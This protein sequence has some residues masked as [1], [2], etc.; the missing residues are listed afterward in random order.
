[1]KVESETA[2][3]RRVASVIAL[4]ALLVVP[5]VATEFHLFQATLVITSAIALLGLNLLTGYGGQISLGHGALYG[6]GAYSA[7]I[8]VEKWGLPYGLGIVGAALICFVVGFLLGL[9]ALRLEGLYLALAT[10]AFA[11]ALPQVLKYKA[12][13]AVT[14]GVQG[15]TLKKPEAPF[16]LVESPDRFMYFLYLGVAVVLFACVRN[17]IQ[18]QTG[19]AIIAIRDS[20]IAASSLGIDIAMYKTTTFAVSAMYAGI[21]GALGALAVQFVSPDSFPLFLSLSLLVGVVVGGLASIS[22]AVFGAL[23]IQF[24][25]NVAEEVSKAAPWAIYGVVLIGVIHLMPD[26]VAGFLTRLAARYRENSPINRPIG[27]PRKEHP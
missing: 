11:A 24:V 25:P 2:R 21:A 26:G 13:Q 5:S 12:F 19:R 22:G 15:I 8:L 6:I 17:L 3:L 10:F 18:G 1:M 27:P 16:G 14:G 9:P 23:F 7:A 20:P 4:V